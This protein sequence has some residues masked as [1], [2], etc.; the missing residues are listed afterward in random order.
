MDLLPVLLLQPAIVDIRSLQTGGKESMY[1]YD[2]INTVQHNTATDSYLHSNS[3]ESR[4][5]TWEAREAFLRPQRNA[6]EP[7]PRLALD[8]NMTV[9]ADEVKKY[10]HPATQ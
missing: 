10:V 3:P 2:L 1:A 5:Q 6:P 7:M 8:D 9:H 4:S